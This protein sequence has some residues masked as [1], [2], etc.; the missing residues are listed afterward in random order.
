MLQNPTPEISL[1]LKR[2]E[3]EIVHIPGTHNCLQIVLS[4]MI[5]IV[6]LF[7]HGLFCLNVVYA[8]L[9]KQ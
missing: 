2:K 9:L 1:H 3:K 4:H 6:F 7:D 5:Y 8:H